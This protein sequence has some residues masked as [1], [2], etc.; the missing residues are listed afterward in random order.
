M[1]DYSLHRTKDLYVKVTT[2]YLLIEND[3]RKENKLWHIKTIKRPQDH[4][5]SPDPFS[6]ILFSEEKVRHN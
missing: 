3:D 1:S 4:E 2:W 5:S 6:H